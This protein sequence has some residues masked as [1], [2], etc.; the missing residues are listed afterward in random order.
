VDEP[1][2]LTD[3]KA[4][5]QGS[6]QIGKLTHLLVTFTTPIQ[7]E[8]GCIIDIQLPPEFSEVKEF[9][10]QVASHEGIFGSAV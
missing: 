6:T 5:L 3:L 8:R 4:E 7:T 9:M 10:S 2:L 1:A